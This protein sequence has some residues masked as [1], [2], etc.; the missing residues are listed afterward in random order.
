[1]PPGRCPFVIVRKNKPCRKALWKRPDGTKSAYCVMHAF[2]DT[3]DIEY[4]TCPFEPKNRMPKAVLAHHLTVCPKALEISK[5]QAQPFF[6]KGVNFFANGST[7]AAEE[8]KEG[9][10][11]PSDQ[12]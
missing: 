2:E 4:E 10:L 8:E 5:V 6:N 9:Q 3:P 11:I 7:Q 1:M 12:F